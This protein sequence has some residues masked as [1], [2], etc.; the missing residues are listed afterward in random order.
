MWIDD[1]RDL[2]SRFQLHDERL[3]LLHE[4]FAVPDAARRFW[5]R[6]G[7]VILASA[8]QAFIPGRLISYLDPRFVLY[9]AYLCLGRP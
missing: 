3:A 1:Y 6:A 8:T 4:L 5:E 7:L 2:G 9:S